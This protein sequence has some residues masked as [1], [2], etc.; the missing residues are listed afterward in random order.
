MRATGL[1]LAA[2][3]M[4]TL[5][6][7]KPVKQRSA[8]AVKDSHH[9]PRRWTEARL[10]DADHK[11]A[12][13]IGLK[14]GFFSD[15]ERQLYEVSDPDHQFYGHHLTA[16]DVHKLVEPSDETLDQVH[17][18]LADYGVDKSKLDYS[19]AKDWITVTLPVA[20]IEQMLNTKY[21]I[22]RHDDGSEVVRTPKWSLPLHLHDHIDTIQP[23]NSWFRARPKAF[24]LKVETLEDPK[25]ATTL[26]SNGSVT[27]VCVWDHVT[28]TCLRTLYGTIDYQTR[29]ADTNIMGLV[30]YLGESNNR[31]DT[32]QFLSKYRPE[33]KS[34]A[35]DFKF[36]SIANGTTSQIYTNR[37]IEDQTN[38][39][40]NLDV[41]AMLGIGWPT[42]LIAYSVGG[43]APS[44]PDAATPI[45]SNEPYLAWL[46]HLLSQPDDE[47][48]RVIST[49]YD[50]DEQTVP[51]SYATRVC[52]DMAQLGA[53]G[54]SLLFA[55]GDEGVGFSGCCSSNDGTDRSSFLP[56]FPSSCPFVT[57]VGATMNFTPE[58]VAQKESK[59]YASGGGFSNY[60]SRPLY[61]EAVVDAYIESLGGRDAGFY[62]PSG[63]GYPDIAGQG[64]SYV[65]VW[66]SRQV[67]VSGT[68]AST[69]AISAIFALVNDAL[70]A[71]GRSPL[72]FLNPWLYKRG[73]KAFTDITSGSAVGCSELGDGL[74]FPAKEGWDAVTGFGTPRFKD[75]LEVL[76]VG[77]ATF[78][79]K[80]QGWSVSQ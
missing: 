29:S 50:D 57:S 63:R 74:G 39:E 56:E 75:I 3:L 66:N 58:V 54:V 28:P 22:Y 47:L 1:L 34:G 65:E 73:H 15:L 80:K 41:Q 18:W 52:N 30:N 10:P 64:Y 69:P 61:Q 23:T 67:R 79:G 53:R 32:F 60:F 5:A 2:G 62:N 55:S 44:I 77:N 25:P 71:A 14:Q 36:D 46:E 11:I 4:V 38:I 33:A 35:Y 40:G 17:E 59:G 51:L 21:S 42:R 12:L 48:A 24:A 70:I 68:S 16:Q 49:S 76:G 43:R 27:D 37:S 6:V 13:R 19:P 9:V 26:C 31:N 7:G 8:F 45:Y 78:T 20:D 72:G